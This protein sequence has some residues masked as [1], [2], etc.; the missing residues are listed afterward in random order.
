M[1]ITSNISGANGLNRHMGRVAR[2]HRIPSQNIVL[3]GAL[4]SE[5]VLNTVEAL[6]KVA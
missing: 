6:L 4:W 3:T 1:V 5:Q 2:L